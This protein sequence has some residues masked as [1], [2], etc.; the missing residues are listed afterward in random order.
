MLLAWSLAIITIDRLHGL[1]QRM[2][3]ENEYLFNDVDVARVALIFQVF[4]FF[5]SL[6]YDTETHSPKTSNNMQFKIFFWYQL[7]T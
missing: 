6:H 7:F 1:G 3:E 2:R 4:F 5:S